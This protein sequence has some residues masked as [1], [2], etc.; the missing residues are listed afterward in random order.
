MLPLPPWYMKSV[1]IYSLGDDNQPTAGLFNSL[2]RWR[3]AE[4]RGGHRRAGQRH[5]GGKGLLLLLDEIQ[6][7]S[8]GCCALPV[9]L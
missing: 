7:S 9:E 6:Q 8:S 5:F 2:T 4:G 3:G 1:V